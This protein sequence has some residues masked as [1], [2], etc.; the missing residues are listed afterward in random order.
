MLC[1]TPKHVFVDMLDHSHVFLMLCINKPWHLL[2]TNRCQ[3][4][5]TQIISCFL[6]KI[7]RSV[8]FVKLARDLVVKVFVTYVFDKIELQ[9]TN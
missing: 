7:G 9:I 5:S 4:I 8:N 2:K 1:T 3:G 6:K